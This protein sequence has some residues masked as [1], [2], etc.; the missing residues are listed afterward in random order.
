[1]P[2]MDGLTATARWRA[3][4]AEQSL[5][6]TRIVALTANALEGDR[7][8]CLAAGTDDFLAKPFRLEQLRNVLALAAPTAPV[9]APPPTTQNV[10][11]AAAIDAVLSL[12]PDGSAGLFGRLRELYVTDSQQLLVALES[13]TAAGDVEAAAK[14]AHT[15]KSSSANL[16]ATRVAELAAKMEA[17]ARGGQLQETIRQLTELRAAHANALDALNAVAER[18]VA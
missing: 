16:G 3:T 2:V 14:A 7:E 5:P 17:E 18:R 6:R 11:D 1:M 10:L 8:A 9:E 13:A 12:D 4:E 15:L